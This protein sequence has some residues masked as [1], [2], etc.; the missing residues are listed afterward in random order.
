M[1]SS[2]GGYPSFRHPGESRGPDSYREFR[3]TIPQN[4][5]WQ[6]DLWVSQLRLAE[7]EP[8]IYWP[9]ALAK[10]EEMDRK[11]ILL[12]ADREFLD[13]AKAKVTALEKQ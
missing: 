4:A 12:P 11:G 10:L 7:F 6:R 2:E 13:I 8:Q 9:K 3:E 1:R 5:G